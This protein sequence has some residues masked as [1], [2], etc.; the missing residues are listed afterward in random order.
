VKIF[1][2]NIRFCNILYFLALVFS[3][4]IHSQEIKKAKSKPTKTAPKQNQLT[5]QLS[6]MNENEKQQ[7]IREPVDFETQRVWSSPRWYLLGKIDWPTRIDWMDGTSTPLVFFPL[8][9]QDAFGYAD[10]IIKRGKQKILE[11]SIQS[12]WL[13]I[14]VSPAVFQEELS[15]VFP[16]GKNCIGKASIDYVVNSKR[17]TAPFLIPVEKGNQIGAYE[18]GFKNTVREIDMGFSFK[19]STGIWLSKFPN[20]P[21]TV[22]GFIGPIGAGIVEWKYLSQY[23]R[24]G[25]AIDYSQNILGPFSTNAKV[26]MSD[27]LIH[28]F[29]EYWIIPEIRHSQK[30]YLSWGSHFATDTLSSPAVSRQNLRAQY[31]IVGLQLTQ[32]IFSRNYFELTTFYGFSNQWSGAGVAQGFLHLSLGYGFYLSEEAALNIDWIKRSYKISGQETESSTAYYGGFKL[33]F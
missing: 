16:Q 24:I 1:I 9:C 5:I 28:N 26:Q 20:A 29:W 22:P 25:V 30:I 19:I 31:P 23:R 3:F 32:Y 17:G 27:L 14:E 4:Q 11:T 18:V 33:H 13:S 7:M 15:I 8:G 12:R 21:T 2:K 6:K 10:A